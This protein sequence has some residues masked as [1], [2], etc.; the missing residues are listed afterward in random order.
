ML[1]AL[2][3]HI[4]GATDILERGQGGKSRLERKLELWPQEEEWY[5]LFG[6]EKTQGFW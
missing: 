5:E 6:L 3:P 2:G 1:S 4:K